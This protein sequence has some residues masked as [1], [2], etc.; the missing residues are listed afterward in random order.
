MIQNL[1]DVEKVLEK[2][3]QNLN[4]IENVTRFSTGVRA[5]YAFTVF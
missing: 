4:G 2:L 5:F 1:K 3:R